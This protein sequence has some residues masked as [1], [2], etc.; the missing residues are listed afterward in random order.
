[1]ARIIWRIHISPIG[2]DA[3]SDPRLLNQILARTRFRRRFWNVASIVTLAERVKFPRPDTLPNMRL[4]NQSGLS[5]RRNEGAALQHDRV[6]FERKAER[7]EILRARD[8]V[9]TQRF[10]MG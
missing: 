3:S 8:S 1:M 9:P 10:R 5:P 6:L 2:G 4:K 7:L